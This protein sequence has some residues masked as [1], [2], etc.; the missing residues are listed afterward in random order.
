V[1]ERGERTEQPT[2]KRLA[3]AR[4]QGQI[5]RTPEASVAMTVLAAAGFFTWA[6]PAW[7][8][9][10]TALV[11]RSLGD[12]DTSDWTASDAE[13]FLLGAL[14]R[15]LALVAPPVITVAACAIAVT[16][17][18]VGFVLTSRPLTPDF[19]R[20][21]PLRGLKGLLGGKA[22]AE[23]AKAPLKLLL[24]GTVAWY[25]VAPRLPEL[26]PAAAR[27][28]RGVIAAFAGLVVTLLWRLGAAHAL[29]AGG[30]YLYQR[31]TIARGLR[32]TRE[33]VKDEARQAEGDPTVRARFRTLHRQYARRRM[34][35]DVRTADV[36]LTNPTH[37][38]VA[39]RYDMQAMKAPKVVAKGARLLAAE[40]RERARAA[41]VPVVENPPLARALYKSV[42]VGGEIPGALYRAVAEV[43]AYVWTLGS[44][45]ASLA[46]GG[47]GPA[48]ARRRPAGAPGLPARPPSVM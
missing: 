34:M 15:F 11:T 36:V 18:Q 29:L 6:G 16:V 44:G 20:L 5:A 17:G 35:A 33:E 40:I 12:L 42:P 4:E 1:D 47:G 46:T 8:E 45:R 3:E 31:W 37:V 43:L 13:R 26:L 22:L 32:M 27:E 28:P 21:D 23:L 41:R 2:G 48:E 25:A 19:G 14:G 30:D 39:L 24:L 9:A 38:A 7:F 10:L